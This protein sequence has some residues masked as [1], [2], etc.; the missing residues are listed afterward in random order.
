RQSK[1]NEEQHLRAA[2]GDTAVFRGALSSKTKAQLKDLAYALK[3]SM[4]GTA[5]ELNSRITEFFDKNETT[6]EDPRFVGI[7]NHVSNSASNAAAGPSHSTTSY[8]TP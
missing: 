5:K 3:L 4:D 7:F 6:R 8:S 1:E 2:L